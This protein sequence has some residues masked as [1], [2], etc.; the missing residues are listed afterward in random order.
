MACAR[1]RG[2]H[3]PVSLRNGSRL[4]SERERVEV[5]ASRQQCGIIRTAPS[6]PIGWGGIGLALECVD[7]ETHLLCSQHGSHRRRARRLWFN[8]VTA[9]SNG[10]AAHWVE[11]ANFGKARIDW[12][13]KFP[14]LPDGIHSHNTFGRVFRLLNGD[15][16]ET[17]FLMRCKQSTR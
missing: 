4:P 16:F 5:R 9:N 15:A 10:R 7:S 2:P 13:R 12:F 14:E 17:C 1:L 8:A 3:P 11:I 6:A